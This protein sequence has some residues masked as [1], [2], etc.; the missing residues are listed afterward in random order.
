MS[1]KSSKHSNLV[2]K[3]I[4]AKHFFVPLM[5]TVIFSYAPN[6]SFVSVVPPMWNVSFNYAPKFNHPQ[7]KT[8]FSHDLSSVLI[9]FHMG[10]NFQTSQTW[11]LGSISKIK[12]KIAPNPK[13]IGFGAILSLI[14]ETDPRNQ[15]CDVRKLKPIWNLI[16]D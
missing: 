16:K 2:L 15:V 4:K 14:F 3:N 6:I 5:F 11:F 13:K 7:K 10:F 1:Q 12:L 9:R 8:P